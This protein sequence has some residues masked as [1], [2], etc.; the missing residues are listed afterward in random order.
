L[1]AL[2]RAA[3]EQPP[4]RLERTRHHNRDALQ[5]RRIR[6][7]RAV[8]RRRYSTVTVRRFDFSTLGSVNSSTPSL[9]L[10]L[11]LSLLTSAGSAT[12]RAIDPREIS[13]R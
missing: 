7:R 3:L 1:L 13:Q 6:P 5:S 2:L 9:R 10:A 12:V 8:K 4:L 11:A